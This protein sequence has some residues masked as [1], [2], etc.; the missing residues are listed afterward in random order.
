MKEKKQAYKQ[1]FD[2][3][4]L[5][6]KK[7]NMYQVSIVSLNLFSNGKNLEEAMTNLESEFLKLKLNYKNFGMLE[8]LNNKRSNKYKNSI[9]EKT[10]LFALK[11]STIAIVFVI[12]FVF[13]TSVVVNKLN[14]ISLVEIIKSESNKM[15]GFFPDEKQNLL[16]LRDLVD[17]VKPYIKELKKINQ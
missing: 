14:Q 1:I 15:K 17:G 16:K 7:V 6:Q 10:L 5:I 3:Q 4:L 11:T 2:Y 9:T 8:Q 13:L 12:S